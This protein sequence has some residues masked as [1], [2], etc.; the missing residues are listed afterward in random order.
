M[1]NYMP[2]KLFSDLVAIAHETLDLSSD[3]LEMTVHNGRIVF[4]SRHSGFC[5]TVIADPLSARLDESGI[6]H[7]FEE[8]FDEYDLSDLLERASRGGYE[9]IFIHPEVSE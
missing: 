8:D 3:S 9:T 4:Q 1:N 2:S 5:V 7:F 6:H